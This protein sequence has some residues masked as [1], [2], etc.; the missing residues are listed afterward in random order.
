MEKLAPLLSLPVITEVGRQL[1]KEMGY[2]RIGDIRDQEGFKKKVLAKQIE[3]EET[4]GTFISDRSTIDCW[5]LWQRWNICKAM[6]E[7]TEK[8]YYPSFEQSKKY[9]HVIYVPPMFPPT[10]DGFRWTDAHYQKQIDRLVRMTLYE[11]DLLSRT[12][13]VQSSDVDKR[14]TEVRDW[15]K[16]AKVKLL[17]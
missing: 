17:Q 14:V 8:Y 6:S 2:D 10:E 9:T 5:V 16:A 15:L 13:V 3:T 11:W 1:C 12:Y 4:M 7:D